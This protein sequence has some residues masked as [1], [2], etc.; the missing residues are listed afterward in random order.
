ML[1]P[2]IH[3]NVGEIFIK[4]HVSREENRVLLCTDE[5]Y[6]LKVDDLKMDFFWFYFL[7]I[8][9]HTHTHLYICMYVCVY[10]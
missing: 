10:I 8:C 5:I 2:L 7:Y 4:S 1:L 9:T 3:K 6:I